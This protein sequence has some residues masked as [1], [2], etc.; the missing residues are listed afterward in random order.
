[1][2][3]LLE[4]NFDEKDLKGDEFGPFHAFLGD[5]DIV[6]DKTTSDKT[7]CSKLMTLG[8]MHSNQNVKDLTMILNETFNNVNG[9]LV[10]IYGLPSCELMID[11]TY[12]WG[13]FDGAKQGP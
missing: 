8:I 7:L 5:K 1:M 9:H 11:K 10:V 12:P 2:I 13:F 3:C 4:I 6:Q